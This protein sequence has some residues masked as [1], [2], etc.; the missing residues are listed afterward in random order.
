MTSL[1][2]LKVALGSHNGGDSLLRLGEE[3]STHLSSALPYGIGTQPNPSPRPKAQGGREGG[4][5]WV[6]VPAQACSP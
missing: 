4:S 5:P 1:M 3:G 2:H 6:L